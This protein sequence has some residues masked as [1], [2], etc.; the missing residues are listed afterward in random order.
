MKKRIIKGLSRVTDALEIIISGI[1]LLAIALSAVRLLLDTGIFS[2]KMP[3]LEIFDD[4]L[5]SA[6][7][8]VVGVEFIK[9]LLKHT[10]GAAIEVLL[11]AIARELVVK[12][13]STWETLV[14]I[15]AIGAVFAIRKYLFID[16]F[17][18]TERY[19]YLASSK[20]KDVRVLSK[21][22]LPVDLELTLGELVEHELQMQGEQPEKG[23]SV[24]FRNFLLRVSSMKDGKI[25][26]VEILPDNG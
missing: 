10:P 16:S 9:M 25:Y 14:G 17:E 18:R 26:T 6:L 8:L 11:Y 23:N 15:L 7:G 1:V 20:I 5:S 3:E 4:F 22:G 19:L 12:H 24:V 21:S 2:G 13:T